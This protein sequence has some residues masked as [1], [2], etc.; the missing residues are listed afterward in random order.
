MYNVQTGGATR[1]ASTSNSSERHIARKKRVMFTSSAKGGDDLSGSNYV[2]SPLFI[3]IKVEIVGIDKN[4]WKK[5]SKG[6]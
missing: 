5:T 4:P 3:F 2:R 1:T 6:S